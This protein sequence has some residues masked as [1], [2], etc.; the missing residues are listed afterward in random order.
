MSIEEIR[1]RISVINTETAKLNN[2]RNQ[3]IGR[4]E[5]LKKQLRDAF[6][7]YKKNYGVELNESNLK[8]ELDTVTKRKEEELNKIERILSLINSGNIEEAN[9]LAGVDEK[10][11]VSS[12]SESDFQPQVVENISEDIRE[13][14]TVAPPTVTP[15]QISE[16]HVAPPS[17]GVSAPH[18]DTVAPPPEFSHV[19]PPVISEP[20]VAPP[21]I[22]EPH[23]APPTSTVTPPKSVLTGADSLEIGMPSLEGF[24]KPTLGSITPRHKEE[25]DAKPKPQVQD[26]GAILNGSAFNPN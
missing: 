11:D 19:A 12:V 13:Q 6:E 1:S 26:F 7:L 9:K 5:T 16:P 15:P 18:N 2:Q 22:S 3:N 23:V 21:P 20:V 25:V 8:A 14:S 4:Q 17:S 24:T 10:S